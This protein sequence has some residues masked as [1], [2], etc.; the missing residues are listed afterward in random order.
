MTKTKEKD[1]QVQSQRERIIKQIGKK[2][3]RKKNQ[4]TKFMYRTERDELKR[5]KKMM[6]S[7]VAWMDAM[8]PFGDA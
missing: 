3:S 2:F 5:Q 4:Q 8:K 7:S 6:M 1:S